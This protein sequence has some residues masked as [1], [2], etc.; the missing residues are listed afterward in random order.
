MN[1]QE[2]ATN[3]YNAKPSKV[4][5]IG[6]DVRGAKRMNFDTFENLEAKEQAKKR[7]NQTRHTKNL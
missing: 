2:T 4:S 3:Y 5:N 1:N 6:T 7:T